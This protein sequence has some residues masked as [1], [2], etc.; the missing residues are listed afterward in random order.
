MDEPTEAQVK[1]FWEWCGF[2]IGE[3]IDEW[4]APDSY[5]CFHG[6]PPL[7]LNNLFKY[8]MPKLPLLRFSYETQTIPKL[9]R[10]ETMEANQPHLTVVESNDPTLALFWAIWE[11]ITNSKEVPNGEGLSQN[12]H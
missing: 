3:Y 11:V 7:N 2:S 1:E 9:Y 4:V 6:M 5:T 10:W 8:A 12:I